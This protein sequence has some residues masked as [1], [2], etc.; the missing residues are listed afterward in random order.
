MLEHKSAARTFAGC[1]LA[2]LLVTGCGGSSGEDGGDTSATQEDGGPTLSDGDLGGVTDSLNVPEGVSSFTTTLQW[3]Q[4][5][6][7]ILYLR[8]SITTA[9]RAPALVMLHYR[10][11]TPTRMADYTDA[12]QFVLQHGAW[13]ILP[14]GIDGSWSDD[15]KRDAGRTDDSGFLQEVIRESLADYPL[16]AKHVYMTGFSKGGFMVERFVCDHPDQ[17]AAASWVSAALLD[18][19]RDVCPATRKPPLLMINGTDD[20]KVP[21][22]GETGVASAPDTAAY[23]AGLNGCTATSTSDLTPRV[24]DGTSIRLQAHTHCT[25]GD[26]VYFYTVNGG[27]HTWPDS[28][29]ERPVKLGPTTRNLDADSALWSFFQQ[30]TLP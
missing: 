9:T 29:Y 13:V 6:R 30:F 8:P 17:L 26:Q 28:A 18:T 1:L 23:F 2:A 22:D 16:D 25:G 11:G 14:Q 5:K 12:S 10:G 20:R 24:D 3:D 7:R 21:Y 19:L 4:R 27:G 15:P